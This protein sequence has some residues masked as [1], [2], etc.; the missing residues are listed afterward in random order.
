MPSREASFLG[1]V[2]F[3]NVFA[4]FMSFSQGLTSGYTMRLPSGASV[5]PGAKRFIIIGSAVVVVL[6]L[7]GDHFLTLIQTRYRIL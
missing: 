5:R 6:G 2:C 3:R 1:R 4:G 7:L